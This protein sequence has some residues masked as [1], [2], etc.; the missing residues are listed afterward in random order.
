MKK[1]V[2]EIFHSH[3][4]LTT[5]AIEA[6]KRD[7]MSD[8]HSGHP[9]SIPISHQV[10]T[11]FLGGQSTPPSPS[12]VLY[13]LEIVSG[14]LLPARHFIDESSLDFQAW[15]A[16]IKLG[17]LSLN[18][19]F[20][21]ANPSCSLNSSVATYFSSYSRVKKISSFLKVNSRWYLEYVPNDIWYL[22]GAFV[23]QN[24]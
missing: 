10:A 17:H 12:Q 1:K 24:F 4:L 7:L 16:Q 5:N 15:N 8:L 2:S 22:A 23:D 9:I 18:H 3:G 19:T 20:S 6:K 21:S 11:T 14:L 13:M